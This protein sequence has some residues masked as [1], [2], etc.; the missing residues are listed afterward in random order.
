MTAFRSWNLSLTADNVHFEISHY[1]P[2]L[3]INILSYS[4]TNTQSKCL[5]SKI[6]N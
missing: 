3:G 1:V 4:Q 2:P 6:N 5:S